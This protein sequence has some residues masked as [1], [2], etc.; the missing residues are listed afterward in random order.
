M[1]SVLDAIDAIN[2]SGRRVTREIERQYVFPLGSVMTFVAPVRSTTVVT[3]PELIEDAVGSCYHKV[4]N[5]S[6]DRALLFI[7]EGSSLV[8]KEEV[9]YDCVLKLDEDGLKSDL[10]LKRGDFLHVI[11]AFEKDGSGIASTVLVRD[12]V[13]QLLES[14]WQLFPA[15]H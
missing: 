4:I 5:D 8:I 6:G 9:L 15:V 10:K 13:E 3:P 14:G 1:S 11:V 2:L 12:G 7:R